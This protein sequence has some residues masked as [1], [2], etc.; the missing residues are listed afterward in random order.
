MFSN[1]PSNTPGVPQSPETYQQHGREIKQ[2][3]SVDMQSGFFSND[4]AFQLHVFRKQQRTYSM[5]VALLLLVALCLGSLGALSLAPTLFPAAAQAMGVG[6]PQSPAEPESASGS[7][8]VVP[9]ESGCTALPT[10][11]QYEPTSSKKSDNAL[12]SA[13]FQA[14]RSRKDLLYAKACAATFVDMY[15]TF[16]A[17]D[18]QTFEACTYMLSAGGKQRFYG[19]APRVSPDE[20]MLPMWRASVQQQGVQQTARAEEPRFIAA[21]YPTRLVAWML[22][23]YRRSISIAGGQPVVERA[24]MTILLVAIPVRGKGTGWQ[25]SQWQN[26]NV[27]FQPSA[28]L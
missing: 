8:T 23:S 26:G 17:N 16:N 25:V 18:P 7:A 21:Q 15:Q 20:H 4:E 9:Q 6:V 11:M 2:N 13:W 27:S 1:S 5:Q 19:Q 10:D 22:V 14:G 24:Q 28:L 12:P 3:S